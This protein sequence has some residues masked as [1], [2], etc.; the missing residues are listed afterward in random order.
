MYDNSPVPDGANLPRMCLRKHH[1][2]SRDDNLGLNGG[3]ARLFGE[4][5]GAV[6]RAFLNAS[7]GS[8]SKQELAVK[9]RRA[10]NQG[11]QECF[12][13]QRSSGDADEKMAAGQTE[14]LSGGSRCVYSGSHTRDV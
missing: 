12:H 1:V 11:A 13:V 6:R 2:Q 7:P 3:I 10:V 4:T 8:C 14:S 9:R 5:A